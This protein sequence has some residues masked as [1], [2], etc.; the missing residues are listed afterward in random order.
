MD[1]LTHRAFRMSYLSQRGTRKIQRIPADATESPSCREETIASLIA[2]LTEAKEEAEAANAAKSAFLATMSHEIRTPINAILG[3]ANVLRSGGV[4]PEQAEHL[5]KIDT[6]SRY[7]LD[8]INK[9]LDLSKIEADRFVLEE[10][11]VYVD[12]LTDNAR[13]LVAELAR[14]KGIFLRVECDAF[15]PHLHGDSTRLQQ[16]LLNYLTNAI[17]FTREGSVTLRALLQEETPESIVVRFEVQDTGIGI[18]SEILPRLF[19]PFEQADRSTSRQYGG[20][21]LGLAITSRLVEMMGG[22]VGVQSCSGVGSTFWF[23]ARLKKISTQADAKTPEIDAEQSLYDRFKG[24]RIL[25][26]EDDP[27]SRLVARSLLEE[28]GLIV[29]TAE[30]GMQAVR[31]AGETMYAVILMD[32]QIPGLNGLAATQQIRN[33]A[34]YRSVPILAMTANVFTEDKAKS[35]EAGM[36]DFL[37]KPFCPDLLYSTLLRWLEK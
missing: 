10:L 11:P 3:M 36:D 32:M 34:G 31:I 1:E 14:S 13:T 4:S 30:D 37:P 7:L 12:A 19:E 29:D 22:N 21:G 28:T 15:P 8:I 17:K 26:V 2:R 18:P 33:L 35:L 5:D 16:A 25:V 27:V 6:A 23:T 20:T 24:K 9:V